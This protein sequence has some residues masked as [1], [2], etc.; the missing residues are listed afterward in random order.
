VLD[1]RLSLVDLQEKASKQTIFGSH[2]GQSFSRRHPPGSLRACLPSNFLQCYPVHPQH[3]PVIRRRPVHKALLFSVTGSCVNCYDA[4]WAGS[5]NG[6]SETLRLFTASRSFAVHLAHSFSP[7]CLIHL[8]SSFHL[9]FPIIL[10]LLTSLREM[11]RISPSN[12]GP[13]QSRNGHC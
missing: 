13:L 9:I 5:L 12:D 11:L 7:S 1:G 2:T 8:L 10:S 4:T 6:S 3:Y